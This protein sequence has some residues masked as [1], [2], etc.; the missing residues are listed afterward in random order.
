[1]WSIVDQLLGRGQRA[2]DG[3]SADDLSI[4][5]SE[6][7]ERI[8][9]TTSGSA[10]PTFRPTSS[11]TAFTQFAPLLLDDVIA[12]IAQLPDKSSSANPLPVHV[13]K[14]V[15]NVLTPFLTHLFNRSQAT[16][17]VPTSFKYSFVTPIL[18]KMGLDEAVYHPTD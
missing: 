3:I 2:C 15:S 7:V 18:K 17:C 14:D 13:L 10:S 1:M 4:F 9:L 12:A 11:G 5:F 8:R 16:G 6:K